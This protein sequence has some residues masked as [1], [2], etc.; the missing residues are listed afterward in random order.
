MTDQEATQETL[1]FDLR[2]SEDELIFLLRALNIGALPG[3]KPDTSFDEARAKAALTTLISRQF[4]R[5]NDDILEIDERIAALVGGGGTTQRVLSVLHDARTSRANHWFYLIPN[6]T[7]HHSSPDPG[8]HRFRTVISGIDLIAHLNEIMSLDSVVGDALAID[9]LSIDKRLYDDSLK[10]A[11]ENPQ[12]AVQL[13]TD[14][15]VPE[16]Y[17]QA[18]VNFDQRTVVMLVQSQTDGTVGAPMLVIKANNNF[19]TAIP[20]DDG[21]MMRLAARS[22]QDILSDLA[23]MFGGR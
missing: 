6:F 1:R 12:K 19:I 14:N 8:V 23:D 16:A 18:L 5:E 9:P 7:I 22:A 15:D 2:I 17:A 4:A 13:L 21:A 11:G 3:Y 20:E 10:L